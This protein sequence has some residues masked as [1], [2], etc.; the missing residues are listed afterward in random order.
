M[1]RRSALLPL[2]LALFVLALPAARATDL[3]DPAPALKIAHWIKGEPVDMAQQQGKGPAVI[4]FWAT[5]CGPCRQTIPH[6]TAMQKQ[7]RDKGVVFIGVS[8]ETPEVVRPFVEK[9][10]ATMDYVVAVDEQGATSDAYMNAFN[11]HGIPHAF[12][13][14]TKGEI[15]WHGH[16]MAGLDKAIDQVLAGT[17]DVERAR[18]AGRALEA[19]QKY[20]AQVTYGRDDAE[21]RALGARV[22]EDGSG[23]A[24]I[25]NEFAW[26]ILTEPAVKFRDLDLAMKAAKAAL[27]ASE[28]KDA[29]ILDTYARALWDNGSK[30]EA[31]EY[32]KKA[33]AAAAEPELKAELEATL[34]Q[35]EEQIAGGGAAK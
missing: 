27:D 22:I 23:D 26:N 7:Y 24:Q 33:V 20:F 4:E 15:L 12:L 18:K 3:G 16:P 25:M 32:Q 17:Y 2:A 1:S 31:L 21:T 5:W 35:Y 29:A 30:A 10:G 28:A 34:R 8:R 9:M 13:I 19:M 14:G 11:V 6:L